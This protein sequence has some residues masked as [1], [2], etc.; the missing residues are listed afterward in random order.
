[1]Q[2]DEV[3]LEEVFFDVVEAILVHPQHL[4]FADGVDLWW[5]YVDLHMGVVRPGNLFDL[6]GFRHVLAVANG[7]DDGM[8]ILGQCVDHADAEVAQGGVVGARKPT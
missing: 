8:A 4:E 6:E 2:V 1:M 5:T 7:E 3:R